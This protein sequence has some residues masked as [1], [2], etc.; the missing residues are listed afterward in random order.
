MLIISSTVLAQDYGDFKPK[1]GS[2][3]IGQVS[4]KLIDAENGSPLA[5]ANIRLFRTND[6]LLEGTITDESGSFKFDEPALANGYLMINYMG[7]EETKI[8]ITLNRN[9]KVE[10]LR[11]V[12]IKRS[13]VNLN[14]VSIN[15]EKPIYE[16]KMEKI[17]YNA[18]NDLNESLDDASDVLRKTPL[19]SVDMDGNVS[20]RGSRG[21]K[22]LVNGKEST[23]LMGTRQ[24]RSK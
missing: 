7:Y 5:F 6:I 10:F 2:H 11:K 8:P 13:A 21:V 3:H 23:F 9:K 20:L 15:E 17:V 22:F 24:V 16:S 4:G 1:N 12:K 19:L 18:E 14:E